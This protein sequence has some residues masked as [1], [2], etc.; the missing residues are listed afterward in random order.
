M[1]EKNIVKVAQELYRETSEGSVYLLS[2]ICE[3]CGFEL[4]PLQKCCPQCLA[5]EIKEQPLPTKGAIYSYTTIYA[6]PAGF[7]GPYSVG[8]VDLGSFRIYGMFSGGE[9]RIGAKVDVE[10]GVIR[11]TEDTIYMGYKY[12][13]AE[14]S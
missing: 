4:F 12:K 9:P 6:A 13:V 2:G 5:E 11:E 8:N 1:A 10:M 7:T 3:K 14:R